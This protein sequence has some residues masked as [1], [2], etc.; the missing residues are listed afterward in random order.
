V[1]EQAAFAYT[2]A[3]NE[4][5]RYDKGQRVQIVD[6]TTVFWTERDSPLEG[7]MGYILDPREDRGD[8][9]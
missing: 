5:L 2:T 1:S 6:A 3:L 4:L 9:A 7:F 8:V